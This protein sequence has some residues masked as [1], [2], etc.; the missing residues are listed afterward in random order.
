MRVER[1]P[2]ILRELRSHAS[3]V[4]VF[5][6]SSHADAVCRLLGVATGD[7]LFW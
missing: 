2:Q 4:Y 3:Q 5:D 6:S 1:L 7:K